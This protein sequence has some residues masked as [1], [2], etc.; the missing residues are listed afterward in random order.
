MFPQPIVSPL[1]MGSVKLVAVGET[2]LVLGNSVLSSTDASDR[3]KYLGF[4][5]DALGIGFSPAVALDEKNFFVAGMGGIGRST[6]AGNSWHTFTA[7]IAEP[8][9]F[10]IVAVSNVL[11]AVTNK[12]MA[13]SVDGGD[14]WTQ[15]STNLLHLSNKPIGALKLL[16]MTTAGDALY[17]RTNQGGSSLLY[18]PPNT[19]TLQRIEGMPVYVNQW[20]E[21]PI[22][23]AA[24]V[25]LSEADQAEL[26][27]YRRSVAGAVVGI[28]GEFAVSENTFYIEYERKL[29]RWTRGHSEWHDTGMQD[30]PVFED[31]YATDGFQ[32]AVSGKVIYLGK[33]DG[34]LFKSG[35]G[36]DTWVN[37][38]ESFPFPLN[39]A[40]TQEQ[41]L[42]KL[43]HFREIMFVASTVCVSTN[44]GVAMSSDGVNWQPFTDSKD[45]PI[46]M[47][48]LAVDGTTLYGVSE[49]G[50]Y[51]LNNT[52]GI[53]KQLTSEVLGR[54]TS[55]VVIG[56][57]LYVGTVRRGLLSLP[58]HS[59]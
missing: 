47:R 9:I 4:H 10:D 17:V 41:L 45:T 40:L 8:Y 43:P 26:A 30:A 36:G 55:L 39:R 29:Y 27:R 16:N 15:I 28:T 7:G 42:V 33:S 53:W 12:G 1:T 56:N 38:T 21:Q 58:L 22:G 6:D 50:V 24:A 25:A 13:K 11:Y 18:L 35:D 20:L 2:V 32:F 46:A 3:W 49:T 37:V 19:D 52:T 31:F 23:T 34:Q 57:I 44:G 51:Q 5:K 59:L 14:Q 54:V 48:Q